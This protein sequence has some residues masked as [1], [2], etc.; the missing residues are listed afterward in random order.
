MHPGAPSLYFYLDVAML[1]L[2]MAKV[3]FVMS[4]SMLLIHISEGK[5]THSLYCEGHEYNKITCK[6]IH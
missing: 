6:R 5:N 3:S 4:S 2:E 1:V